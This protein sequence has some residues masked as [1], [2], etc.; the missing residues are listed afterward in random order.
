MGL[1]DA[2]SG[3]DEAEAAAAKNAALY[4]Q[5]GIDT[6][7]LY[8]GYRTD[9][10][11]AL[12]GAKGAA[13]GALGEGLSTST[14]LLR[15][16]LAGAADAGRASVDAYAPLSALGDTYG[17]GVNRYMDALGLNGPGA[18][19]RAQASY[20]ASPG[21]SYQIN[22]ATRA[23]TNAA[24]RT[25]NVG[26]GSTALAIANAARGATAQDYGTQYLDRLAGF[27][28]PQLQ[29]TAGAATGIAGANKTLADIYSQGY[30]GL[31][32]AYGQNATQ[33][34]ALESG[35][36]SDLSNVFGN[37]TAGQAQSLKDVTAGNAQANRDV[38]AAGQTDASNLWGLLGA[39]VKAASGAF[40]PGGAGTKSLYG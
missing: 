26:G 27:I 2:F 14:D 18:A 15:Q 40:A 31:A 23:G 34:A 11:G 22:E 24:S 20:M 16:G 4:Q 7:N 1:F 10:T 21:V 9:A 32:S 3:S 12:T 25:G 28:N 29:A 19:G 35:Y 6:G 37:Y 33:R 13:L 5:Y 36:G 39:G 17:K 38:A 8:G 30:G